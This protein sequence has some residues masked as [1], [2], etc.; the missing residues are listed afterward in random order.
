MQLLSPAFTE[1]RRLRTAGNHP[2]AFALIQTSAPASDADALEAVVSLYSAG[3]LDSALRCARAWPWRDDWTRRTGTAF[4]GLIEAPHTP[5]VMP[6]A[7]ADAKAAAHDPAAGPAAAAVYLLLLQAAGRVPEAAAWAQARLRQP[8]QDEPLLLVALAELAVATGDP[9]QA[10]R[11]A[12]TVLA[13]NPYDFRALMAAS[14]A[15][16]EAGN[17]H[18]ALGNALRA[19]RVQPAAAAAVLQ[20]M[21]CHN[22]LGD[23]IAALADYA[24]FAAAGIPTPALLSELGLAHAGLGDRAGAIAA[25]ERAL[26]NAPL[27]PAS[28]QALLK[29]YA[30]DDGSE[31]RAALAALE[32]RFAA[33]IGN[34]IECGFALAL[35][36]LRARD[37]D[38]CRARLEHCFG[39]ARGQGVIFDLLP[40]PV[41]E[42]LL[43]H[44][45]EQL[46]LLEQRGKLSAAGHDAL[47]VL[48]S[49]VALASDSRGDIAPPGAAGQALRE[50]IATVHHD[51]DPPF[52][53][54]ALGERDYA[55]LEADY[56]AQQP[57]LLVIDDFLAPD[58]LAALRE[59]CEEAT[60]W[61][62]YNDGGYTGAFL[63]QGFRPRVL[64][65]IADELKQAL[66]Q[67]IGGHPL[68]QAWAFKYDQRHQG[69][70]VHADFARVNV[71]FWITPQSACADPATGGMVVYDVPAPADWTFADFNTN[72][73]K[74]EAFLKLH[75]AQSR[76][77]PYRENR[78]VLFDSRLFHVTDTIRFKPGYTNRRINVTLLYGSGNGAG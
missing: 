29:L 16:L 8:P 21:R 43:R 32:Q 73:A 15:H 4:A 37:L 28:L 70:K 27:P 53:G 67:V 72:A 46:S 55:A 10:Y 66:P 40:W 20:M 63:G 71:N 36:R 42:P 5:T 31:A 78:C 9:E 61:K 68:M 45:V 57:S 56:F 44:D 33:E 26:A 25:H 14:T 47:A 22:R 3:N 34:D 48:K 6:A 24:S 39:L 17:P 12:T 60:V 35:D 13:M 76:R 54:R 1:I 23:H 64:L 38:G 2:A 49:A 74:M 30:T 62:A 65:A 51:P 18:E 41:P 58:A 19:N 75:G 50:A 69:I 59:Y 7:L 11:R 77:I 52:A